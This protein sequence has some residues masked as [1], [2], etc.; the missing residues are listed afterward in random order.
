[1]LFSFSNVVSFGQHDTAIVLE[2][3]AFAR[4]CLE[5][6]IK[7]P[8]DTLDCY[9]GV[10][11]KWLLLI[12][13]YTTGLSKKLNPDARKSLQAANEAWLL[14]FEKELEETNKIIRDK[15]LPLL[16]RRQAAI[17]QYKFAENAALQLQKRIAST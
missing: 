13:Q 9:P 7:P 8:P 15:N 2:P 4:A 16:T 10:T 5:V 17:R 1:M 6:A 12:D 3:V 14:D 11:K